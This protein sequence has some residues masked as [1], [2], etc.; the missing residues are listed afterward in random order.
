MRAKAKLRED[1]VKIAF[2]AS[3]EIDKRL[4]TVLTTIYLLFNEGYYSLSQ[5]TT[6]RKD[7]C[8][9]AIRLNYLLT[10]NPDTNKPKVNALLAL[11]CFHASRF[12]ARTNP[13]GEQILY[14]DQDTALWDKELIERGKFYLNQAAE[15][16]QLTKY[17]IEAGIAWCHTRHEDTIEKWENILQLYN[18]LLFI[19][20]S[21]MAALNRT[22]AL[23]KANGKPAAIA[24]AE[25]LKLEDNQL[26]YMLLGHLY[27]DVDNEKAIDHLTTAL[28]LAK[29]EADKG[30]IS[31]SI[32]KIKTLP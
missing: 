26:Y 31:K 8:Q 7:L 20:Y 32:C 4:E 18:R 11:M 23:A 16:N 5:N 24:E 15:G 22:Y 9:E 12:E 1:N 2:P 17:H 27:T 29:S 14:A 21:P 6:V 10:I 19:E 28:K 13:N 30:T 3:A 25:K